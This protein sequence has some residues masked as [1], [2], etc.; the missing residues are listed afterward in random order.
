MTVGLTLRLGIRN[1]LRNRS[2]TLLSMAAVIAGI[3]VLVMGRA[4][5]RGMNENIIRAQEDTFSAHVLIRPE[6][7]PTDVMAHPVDELLVVSPELSA[8]LDR[9]AVAWTARTLFTPSLVRGGDRLRVRAFGFD[10]ETDAATFPRKDWQLDGTVPAAAEDGILVGRGVA[11]L[12]ELDV[13]DRVVLQTRTSEGAI[14]ALDVPISGVVSVG[15][16][17]VDALGILV[18][19][20]LTRDLVRNGD[21]VS[22]VA[23]RL[24]RREAA[25]AFVGRLRPVVGDAGSVSTWADETRDLLAIQTFRQRAFD[26][27]VGILLLMSAAAIANTILMA[28]Y[29]RVREV[30]TLRALGMTGGAVLALFVVEGSLIGLVGGL[31]GAVGAGAMARHASIHGIDLSAQLEAQQQTEIPISATLYLEYSP[32]M[33]VYAVLFG[34]VV[35]ALASI[36]P[37]RVAARMAPADAVRAK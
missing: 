11:D 34:V 18:P 15:N 30:G 6:G 14:N 25:E 24:G 13:G 8:F 12:L 17:V 36:Y 32:E 33:V 35:A 37:A 1:L 22:H 28:A 19:E 2:R 7:Y 3:W 26:T 20:P 4:F 9:E 5:V 16:A 31:I 21:G 10:P 29:E 27:L 23:V